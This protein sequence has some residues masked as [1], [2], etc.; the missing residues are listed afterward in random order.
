MMAFWVPAV[1]PKPWKSSST[2][3]RPRVMSCCNH[4]QIREPHLSRGSRKNLDIKTSRQA[5]RLSFLSHQQ[6]ILLLS[7]V[8]GTTANAHLVIRGVHTSINGPPAARLVGWL[9]AWPGPGRHHNGLQLSTSERAEVPDGHGR[10]LLAVLTASSSKLMMLTLRLWREAT[11]QGNKGGRKVGKSGLGQEALEMHSV[12]EGPCPASPAH[13]RPSQTYL[14]EA[15][16]RP[17]CEGQKFVVCSSHH[18]HNL[19]EG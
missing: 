2:M 12:P 11:L 10:R 9:E 18:H 5:S 17:A 6:G 19:A 8:L 16:T 13:C 7:A 3:P 15:A 14:P 1:P 4:Q